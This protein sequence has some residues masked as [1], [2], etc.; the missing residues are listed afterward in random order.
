MVDLPAERGAPGRVRQTGPA[1]LAIARS[2]DGADFAELFAGTG[3][4]VTQ[5]EDMTSVLWRK[6]C[7]NAAG[8]ISAVTLSPPRIARHPA[9]ARFMHEVVSECIA[10]GRAEGANLDDQIADQVVA[11]AQSSPSDAVNS[12][13]ADR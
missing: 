2:P 10:V 4:Q 1:H 11:G 9:I 8:A 13:H 6:L 3:I 7:L 12:L 5:E